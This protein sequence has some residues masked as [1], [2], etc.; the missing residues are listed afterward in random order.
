MNKESVTLKIDEQTCIEMQEY[1]RALQEESKGEYVHFSCQINDDLHMTIYHSKN[2][3]KAVFL[4]TN[5]LEEARRWDSDATINIPKEK[6]LSIWKDLS[7]Q[8]GSDEVGTGDFFGPIIVCAA[9]IDSSL[10][11]F[12]KEMGVDDSKKITDKKIREIVPQIIDKVIY[13]TH[14]CHPL[15]FNE[16]S[17]KGYSMNEIKAILHNDALTKVRKLVNT[18]TICYIDQFCSPYNYYAYLAKY[19]YD[20]IKT[21]IIFETK[22]ESHYPS[23]AVASMIA[24]YEF[25]KWF[26]E[27]SIQYDIELLKGASLKVDDL[28]SYLKDKYGLQELDK[29]VKKSFVNYE[30]LLNDN[31]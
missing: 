12:L 14:I 24:R 3:F 5:S 30:K 21:N 6:V 23:V 25:L 19:K 10:I 11:P 4:G 17:D 27:I 16:M 26:D 9:Y 31:N 20:A 7:S 22:G 1:Y 15:K 8:I 13:K 18:N 2:G 28:A 29:L